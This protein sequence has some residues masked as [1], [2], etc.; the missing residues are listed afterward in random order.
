ML[1]G[2]ILAPLLLT[3]SLLVTSVPTMTMA[4]EHALLV[5]NNSRHSI[6]L[7]FVSRD[8]AE[9]WGPDRLSGILSDR[10][11]P[12]LGEG[13]SVEIDLSRFGDYCVFDVRIVDDGDNQRDYDNLNLCSEPVIDYE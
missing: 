13:E 11:P 5:V 6:K 1:S 2:R 9:H 12:I 4:D 7:V 3:A 8:D 10:D